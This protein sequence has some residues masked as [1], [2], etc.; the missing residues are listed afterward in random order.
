MID[1]GLLRHITDTIVEGL[2]PHR[3][4]LFGSHAK[5]N[6]GSQSD[7]DLF[8][9]MDS[10]LSPPRRALQVNRLFGLR[11]WSMDIVVYTPEEVARYRDTPG[12][13]ISEVEATG[14]VLYEQPK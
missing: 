9:E 10:P 4:V 1:E 3:V 12:T 13:L 8:I 14:I 7:I 11:P 6:A 2:R 5:G